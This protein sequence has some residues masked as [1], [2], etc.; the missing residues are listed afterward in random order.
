MAEGLAPLYPRLWRFCLV[1]TKD[2]ATADDLAQSACARALEQ[3]D[4]FAVGTNLDRWVFT[5][6]R[7]LWL[8]DIRHTKL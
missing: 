6:A 4:K 7:R 8:N 2:R 5:I 3:S 1:L